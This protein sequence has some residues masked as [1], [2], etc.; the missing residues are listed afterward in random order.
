[1]DNPYLLPTDEFFRVINVS[2]GRSSGYQLWNILQAHDGRLPNSA[3]AVFCNTGKERPETLDFLHRMEREWHVPITWLEYDYRFEARGGTEDPKNVH[4]VVTY[5]TASRA[6]EPFET[7]IAR[8][9]MLPNIKLRKCTAELK[10]ETALRFCRRDL[11]LKTKQVRNVLGIRHDEPR[12]WEKA[13]YE[14][15]ATE[16]PMVHA[17]A[18]KA[19]VG[20]FWN[21]HPFDL[22]IESWMGNCDGCFL[23]GAGN[24]VETF[25]RDP[26][27]ADW[28]MEQEE[29]TS[30][31]W[32]SRLRKKEMARWSKRWTYRELLEYS[33]NQGALDLGAL[34][35]EEADSCFCTD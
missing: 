22:G 25:R 14:E 1:M 26:A 8:S 19:D 6:G 17:R 24:L 29:S 27:C 32:R 16:Y 23:K 3:V 21:N 11:G 9:S 5:E 7:L 10:V 12:R 15:C 31:S 30:L 4:R 2:G 35:D 20:R 13:L 34:D 28:W 18:T 33:Q